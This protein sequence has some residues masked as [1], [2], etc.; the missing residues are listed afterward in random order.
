ML[1]VG[2][3]AG[4]SCG[5]P[6][7]LVVGEA[8]RQPVAVSKG[9]RAGPCVAARHLPTWACLPVG[10]RALRELKSASE[11][12]VVEL[13]GQRVTMPGKVVQRA[14]IRWRT[15][16]G[17]RVDVTVQGRQHW[18]RGQ[19]PASKLRFVLPKGTRLYAGPGGAQVGILLGNLEVVPRTYE[20]GHVSFEFETPS[21]SWSHE[22]VLLWAAAARFRHDARAST[23]PVGQGLPSAKP[24]P[25]TVWRRLGAQL[26]IF[27]EGNKAAETTVPICGGALPPMWLLERRRDRYRVAVRLVGA[28]TRRPGPVLLRGWIYLEP[29]R[30]NGPIKGQRAY[31]IRVLH[32]AAL[33]RWYAGK[34]HVTTVALPLYLRTG[35]GSSP[36][37]VLAAGADVVMERARLLRGPMRRYLKV[38]RN[39]VY[40]V[41]YSPRFFR[42]SAAK[43]HR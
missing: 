23:I 6:P 42:R 39:G 2:L 38:N 29:R 27:V 32:R 34:D 1:A 37:G 41:P 9:Q 5:P 12:V 21:P 19:T 43:G 26:S 22:G 8:S 4:A 33:R 20:R 13:N 25:T 18:V 24:A 14:P 16:G 28:Q 11:R 36:V 31:C 35:A 17:T 15:G 3:L 10:R 7:R 40:Y 30:P